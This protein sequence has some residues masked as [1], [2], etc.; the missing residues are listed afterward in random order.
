MK[1]M[2]DKTAEIQRELAELKLLQD[3]AKEHKHNLS[4]MGAS[5]YS[6]GNEYEIQERLEKYFISNKIPYQKEVYIENGRMDF[7]D[8]ERIY[9]VKK[10]WNNQDLFNAIGQLTYYNKCHDDKYIPVVC[11][12]SFTSKQK[13]ILKRLNIE[14]R[15]M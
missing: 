12:E 5:R 1:L 3:K 4:K 10:L 13:K 9:E 14:W 15:A 11:S 6:S 8:G 7:I 2:N